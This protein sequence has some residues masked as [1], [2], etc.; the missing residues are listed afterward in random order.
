VPAESAEPCRPQG[1]SSLAAMCLGFTR[2]REEMAFW[3]LAQIVE[4]YQ[5]DP[6]TVA[7][8]L[9][10]A[11]PCL[12][13]ALG[14]RALAEAAA[15]LAERC[16]AHGFVG[17]LPDEALLE[18]WEE[19]LESGGGQ[20]SS[21]GPPLAWLAGLAWWAEGDLVSAL[22]AAPVSAA[23]D[24]AAA[25]VSQRLLLLGRRLPPVARP[26][27]AGIASLVGSGGVGREVRQCLPGQQQRGSAK[28]LF[29]SLTRA[30]R[31]R[32]SRVA[33]SSH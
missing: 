18:L 4:Q 17:C 15:L 20:A 1:F 26:D 7:G 6:A 21:P 25:L 31:G 12:A 28:A 19:L 22:A 30:L 10:S 32:R 33:L 13:A 2:G 14:S 9:A 16:L 29:A 3:L 23:P 5:G 8:L 24:E 11:T 27:L